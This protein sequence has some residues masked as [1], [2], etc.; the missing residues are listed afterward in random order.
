M[1]FAL[2]AA[3]P[4]FSAEP[5]PARP[6]IAEAAK[7]KTFLI[8]LRLTP[9]YHDQKAWTDADN[10]IV[11]DHFKRLKEGFAAG[12]VILAGRTQETPD[13]T[14]GLI[15]FTAVD[16]AAARDFMNADP[17]IVAG[18]MTGTLHP[19]AISLLKKT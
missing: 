17:C 1:A 11:N 8:V 12:Q 5:S 4:L 2:V 9:K 14:Q 6:T 10:A 3:Q 19:Y 7:P 15:I 13:K 18:I 16:E